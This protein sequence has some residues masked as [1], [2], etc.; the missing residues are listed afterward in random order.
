MPAHLSTQ[1]IA[2]CRQPSSARHTARLTARL[3][4]RLSPHLSAS[5]DRF[6][7]LSLPHPTSYYDAKGLEPAFPFGHGLSYTTFRYSALSIDADSKL[8]SCTLSNTGTLDGAEVLQLYLSYPPT[9]GE[10]PQQLR[11]FQKVFLPAGKSA[12]VTFT[13]LSGEADLSTW[14]EATH[15]WKGVFGSFGVHVGSSSRDIRLSGSLVV[16]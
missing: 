7:R 4:T 10:P 5:T 9:A 11:G 16:A 13:P 8:V 14:D 3:A 1:L 15:A 2:T 12:T 6:H